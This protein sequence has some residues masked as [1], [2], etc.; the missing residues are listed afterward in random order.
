MVWEHY[1]KGAGVLGSYTKR[2][3]R[4]SH[5][6]FLGGDALH[7]HF[8]EPLSELASGP[9]FLFSGDLAGDED[10]WAGPPLSSIGSLSGIRAPG[11]VF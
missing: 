2:C 4:F 5:N 8:R 6:P 10:R 11:W 7:L 9:L 3:L 1:S